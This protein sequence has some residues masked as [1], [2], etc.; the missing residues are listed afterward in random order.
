M[1]FK[2]VKRNKLT[3]FAL[4]VIFTKMAIVKIKIIQN[5]MF[6]ETLFQ[7]RRHD[8]CL[9]FEQRLCGLSLTAGFTEY[10]KES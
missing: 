9:S 7:N 10:F 2:D 5:V 4:F 8:S 6:F 1:T 3:S